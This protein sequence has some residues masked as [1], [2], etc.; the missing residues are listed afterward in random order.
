M[1]TQ[2]V[3]QQARTGEKSKPIQAIPLDLDDVINYSRASLKGIGAGLYNLVDM[4]N[5]PWGKVIDPTFT[6]L[7]DSAVIYA[8]HSKHNN[9]AAPA[10]YIPFYN[11]VLQNQPAYLKAVERMGARISGFK[12]MGNHF[13]NGDGP[14]RAE[15]IA[16]GVT[17]IFAPGFIFKGISASAA[18]AK[19]VQNFG[20]VSKPPL[21]HNTKHELTLQKPVF[22]TLSVKQVKE[23]LGQNTFL[24]VYTV[25]KEL[26]VAERMLK[27]PVLRDGYESSFL[28]HHELAPGKPVYFAGELETYDGFIRKILPQSGHFLPEGS[29]LASFMEKT[30]YQQGYL[31]ALG[32][33]TP[34]PLLAKSKNNPRVTQEKI[35]LTPGKETTATAFTTA[36]RQVNEDIMKDIDDKTQQH[37]KSSSARNSG[38]SEHVRSKIADATNYDDLS[39]RFDKS[40]R[41][42]IKETGTT[43]DQNFLHDLE[44]I[45][46]YQQQYQERLK[47]EKAFSRKIELI[48]TFQD[49]SF[50]FGQ[51]GELATRL[52]NPDLGC[53]LNVMGGG[54]QLAAGA[55]MMSVNPLAGIGMVLS[56]I[57]GISGGLGEPEEDNRFPLLFQGIQQ[58]LQDLHDIKLYLIQANKDMYAFHIRTLNSL[59]NELGVMQQQYKDQGHKQN[60]NDAITHG[61]INLLIEQHQKNTLT[62]AA[63]YGKGRPLPLAA[64]TSEKYYGLMPQ[65][66]QLTEEAFAHYHNGRTVY[67]AELVDG[68]KAAIAEIGTLS[69]KGKM[70][71]YL[72]AQFDDLRAEAHNACNLN[73]WLAASQHYLRLAQSNHA[74][75]VD[76]A[77]SSKIIAQGERCLSVIEKIDAQ[78]PALFDKYFAEANDAINDMQK[79]LTYPEKVLEIVENKN[80]FWAITKPANPL[81]I[82]PD[83]SKIINCFHGYGN[84]RVFPFDDAPLQLPFFIDKNSLDFSSC[85][86]D[87][88]YYGLEHLGMGQ[89]Q[90]RWKADNG[91]CNFAP[92]PAINFIFTDGTTAIMWERL[93]IDGWIVN[94]PRGFYQRGGTYKR[95]ASS[96][97]PKAN[98]TL[99]KYRQEAV[100]EKETFI[101]KNVRTWENKLVFN[102]IKAREACLALGIN[103]TVCHSIPTF[104]MDEA[105]LLAPYGNDL[106]QGMKYNDKLPTHS[107]LSSDLDAFKTLLSKSADELTKQFKLSRLVSEQ[108]PI[109]RE[110]FIQ[111]MLSNGPKYK[112]DIHTS[113]YILGY[114]G[115]SLTY[116]NK[117]V[118]HFDKESDVFVT[119]PVNPIN[120]STISLFIDLVNRTALSSEQLNNITVLTGHTLINRA[121]HPMVTMTGRTLR[122]LKEHHQEK[123]SRPKSSQKEE[124][125]T[126]PSTAE[127]TPSFDFSAMMAILQKN[128]ATMEKVLEENNALRQEMAELRD[129][130]TITINVDAAEPFDASYALTHWS[131]KMNAA[132]PDEI[133]CFDPIHEDQPVQIGRRLSKPWEQLSPVVTDCIMQNGTR[134]CWGDEI[135]YADT[136]KHARLQ[137]SQSLIEV[138][139]LNIAILLLLANWMRRFKENGVSFSTLDTPKQAGTSSVG[140]T[141]NRFGLW[142]QSKR[143]TNTLVIQNESLT[144]HADVVD[145]I[146][147]MN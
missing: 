28:H 41:D 108:L 24:F 45:E 33:Y 16:E 60:F 91:A 69:S 84:K 22:D 72:A 26:L 11:Y 136:S 9:M 27:K 75:D 89:F 103:T 19:N 138:W 90:I 18:M 78:L 66:Y 127:T 102:L 40:T 116:D 98:E 128:Q 117:T 74:Y 119:L 133:T 99:V 23:T 144:F 104:T 61:G 100:Q 21:F 134:F 118:Y 6:L 137:L 15:M 131:C 35:N 106:R 59:F 34:I 30:F 39:N 49:A 125:K 147:T 107:S 140:K 81:I 105:V 109:T 92:C 42:T 80:N 126:T 3:F 1:P 51:A 54:A 122:Q 87:K 17:G 53:A 68:T 5:D 62:Q 124:P 36:T 85:I 67:K 93:T 57:N 56:G 121:P 29:H 25:D 10:E 71:G 63:T 142:A 86:M 115:E 65:L 110:S 113:Y 83:P 7:Y 14:H 2:N 13:V 143:C 77:E 95:D 135:G 132:L 146:N 73:I 97:A 76:G 139:M 50:A 48:N 114:D 141:T 4:A 47:K 37:T 123:L 55:M 79:L 64:L 88:E 12:G 130:A 52:G 38:L 120:F 43:A 44:N 20:T 31:E 82:G 112:D 101:K 145:Y 70:Y 32:T 58:I 129:K 8:A 46:T 94:D 96:Y 111:T